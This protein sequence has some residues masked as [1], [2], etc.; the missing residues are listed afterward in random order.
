MSHRT[1]PTRPQYSYGAGGSGYDSGGGGGS[2]HYGLE[3]DN[4]EHV[5]VLG[6]KLS[7]LKQISIAIGDELTLQKD[8]LDGLGKGFDNTGNIL[9]ATMR[10]FTVMARTQNGRW[11]WY[12]ILFAVSVFLYVY[13]FRYKK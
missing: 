5:G 1:R 10:R 3:R 6:D 9:S 13:L 7:Q 4:D 11:M 2:Y 12:L 8:V